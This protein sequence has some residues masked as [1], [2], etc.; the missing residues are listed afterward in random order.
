MSQS[1]YQPPGWYH[2]DGDPA[3]TKR[4]WDGEIWIGEP[5][6]MPS[7]PPAPSSPGAGY[8]SQP[9]PPTAYPEASQATA[10]LVLGILSLVVCGILGPFAWHMGN[11]E[12][13][14]IDTGRRD[15]SNRGNAQAG[16]VLGIISTVMLAL[17]VLFFIFAL[18][19]LAVVG[20]GSS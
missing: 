4:Y 11:A 8:A 7:A 12:I 9:M 3:G 5:Q 17:V 16:R 1:Q 10:S 14:G 18:G 19:S 20:A 2:G 13:Q 15:P 6:V